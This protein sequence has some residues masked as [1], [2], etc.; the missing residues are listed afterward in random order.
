MEAVSS[1]DQLVQEARAAVGGASSTAELRELEI[2]YLGKSG[3]I[4]GMTRLIGTLPTK[5]EKQAFGARVN[6]AKNSLQTYIEA[7]AEA[8]KGGER[9]EQSERERIDVTMPGRRP[10]IGNEHVLAQTANKVK[11]VLGGLGF[12]YA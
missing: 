1:V 5:E 12:Q 8:L 11:R 3:L 10:R 4:T 2:K 6:D 7:R 9:A